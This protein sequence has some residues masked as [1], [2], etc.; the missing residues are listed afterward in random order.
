MMLLANIQPPDRCGIG[1]RFS[2]FPGALA[3][4]SAPVGLDERALNQFTGLVS[5]DHGISRAALD[6]SDLRIGC[7]GTKHPEQSH[8]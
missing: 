6:A 8:G 3:P 4:S 5:A 1:K 2:I 7:V